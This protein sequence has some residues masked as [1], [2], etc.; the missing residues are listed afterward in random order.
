MAKKKGSKSHH[1]E[2]DWTWEFTHSAV[3]RRFTCSPDHITKTLRLRPS[4]VLTTGQPN[5]RLKDR[6]ARIN[7]WK[8]EKTWHGTT[9]DINAGLHIRSLKRLVSEFHKSRKKIASVVGSGEFYFYTTV[10]TNSPNHVMS[11]P[12]QIA[13]LLGEI[14]ADWFCSVWLTDRLREELSSNPSE[15]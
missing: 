8:R 11:L 2:T 5:P 1:D 13:V 12:A 3:F 10:F 15:L 6:P 14:P 9:D 7:C 4:K